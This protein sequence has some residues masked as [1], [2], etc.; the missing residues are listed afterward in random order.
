MS[1]NAD[2]K[3]DKPNKK[4]GKFFEKLKAIKHIEIIIAVIFIA[5]VLL[6]Y[7]SSGSAGIFNSS[8]TNDVV[9]DEISTTITQYTKDMEEKIV[10]VLAN[11]K[12]AGNVS[13]MLNF[14]QGSELKIAYTTETITKTENAIETTTVTQSPVLV[15]NDNTTSPIVLQ[16][17]LPKPKNIIVVASGADDVNVRLELTRAVESLLNLPSSAIQIFTGN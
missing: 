9:E 11:I 17:I 2:L 10:S 15:T 5:I 7:L 12:G 8:N 13:V 1:E 3:K 4:F 6:I 14:E 16:E